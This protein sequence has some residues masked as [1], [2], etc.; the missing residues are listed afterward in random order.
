MVTDPYFVE[1]PNMGGKTFNDLAQDQLKKS[2]LPLDGTS[3]PPK[4][5]K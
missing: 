3:T 5:A 2:D 1:V 4:G